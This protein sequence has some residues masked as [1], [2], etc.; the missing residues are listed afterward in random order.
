MTCA[1]STL[2]GHVSPLHPLPLSPSSPLAPFQPSLSLLLTD[3]L[4]IV[5]F[6]HSS[7]PPLPSLPSSSSFYLLLFSLH[8]L[9]PLLSLVILTLFICSL[10]LCFL[11]PLK[12]SSSRFLPLFPPRNFYLPYL[13][14]SISSSPFSFLLRHP[15]L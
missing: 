4:T 6:C 5:F 13:F 11:S 7:P 3:S 14:Y 8:I 1:S 15:L 10:N 12:S 2:G 9:S